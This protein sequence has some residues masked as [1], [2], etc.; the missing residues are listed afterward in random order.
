MPSIRQEKVAQLL[1]RELGIFF[2]QEARNLFRGAMI[3]PTVV[4]ITPDLKIARVYIS[5]FLPGGDKSE[6]LELVRAQAWQ[7]RR[8]IGNKVA[9]QLRVVPEFRFQEDDS[10]D[11]AERIDEL[12]S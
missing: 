3:T 12:L 10:L 2:Q 7:V 8:D 11:Y 1:K 6:M 9:K 4:Q 5:I